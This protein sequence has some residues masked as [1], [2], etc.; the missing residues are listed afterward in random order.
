MIVFPASYSSKTTACLLKADAASFSLTIGLVCMFQFFQ[1]L[2]GDDRGGELVKDRS[3]QFEALPGETG[4]PGEKL[5]DLAKGLV[6]AIAP[7]NV[8]MQLFIKGGGIG[9]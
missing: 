3:C 2:P 7:V 4:R 6:P 8:E 9:I 1:F 5:T